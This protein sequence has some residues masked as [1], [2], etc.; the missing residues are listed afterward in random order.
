M[1]TVGDIFHR[2]RSYL[3]T[4]KDS[5]PDFCSSMILGFIKSILMWFNNLLIGMGDIG[6]IIKLVLVIGLAWYIV[7]KVV[8]TTW[9][10]VIIALLIYLALSF[11]GGI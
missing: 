9:L 5:R 11:S 7:K 2:S 6:E 4:K 3:Q 1:K 10:I 8:K